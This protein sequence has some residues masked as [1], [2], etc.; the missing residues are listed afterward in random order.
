MI[1]TKHQ[2]LLVK[3]EAMGG[4][5]GMYRDMRNAYKV[6]VWKPER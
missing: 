5:C 1:C 3:E 2:V 4:E 6:L